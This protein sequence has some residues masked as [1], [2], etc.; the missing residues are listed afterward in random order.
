MTYA[1]RLDP[2]AEGLLVCLSGE[3]CKQKENYL[4][5][6]KEYEFEI[7]VGFKTDTHDLLGLVQKTDP[8]VVV[9][10]EEIVKILEGYKGRFLQTYPAFS[11]KPINGVPRFVH[12][13]V[14]RRKEE[15][16]MVEL[17]SFY[18]LD[19]KNITSNE[20][21]Y[22]VKEA[23][24]NVQGHFR[25]KKIFDSWAESILLQREFKIYTFKVTV[26][27]GFYIRQLVDDIGEKLR[28]PMTTFWI[29]R[30][31]IGEYLQPLN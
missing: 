23:T 27:S 3:E 14:G 16:H 12:A 1:G 26:S 29:K 15:R 18:F 19:E 6:T 11:S 10:Q 31:K 28:I 30:T 21:I 8:S 2:M 9:S 7:L 5:L 22:K 20:L 25:Q 13:K 4:S 24:E 17:A